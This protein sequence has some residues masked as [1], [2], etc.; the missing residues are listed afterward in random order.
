M[1]G[2]LRAF[3]FVRLGSHDQ[4]FCTIFLHQ[5]CEMPCKSIVKYCGHL[6]SIILNSPCENENQC[7]ES[8]SSW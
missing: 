5:S 2:G 8:L 4:V 6:S 7:L 3:S 1:A